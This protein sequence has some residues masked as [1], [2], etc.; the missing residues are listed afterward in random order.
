M[1]GSNAS[2]LVKSDKILIDKI[3]KEIEHLP[4]LPHVVTKVVEMTQST[5]TNIEGISATL[6]QS[7]AAKVLKMANSAY[8]GGGRSRNV[9]SIRHA[10]V[11]IGFDALKEIV[12]TASFF[13]TFHDARDVQSLQPLWE[14]SQ[15]AAQIAKRM[16]WIYGYSNH[17]EAYFSGLV[18]D[19]GK[20]V[21]NQYFPEQYRMIQDLIQKG[22]EEADAEKATIGLNHAEIGGKVCNFWGFPGSVADAISHHHDDQW[23]VNPKLGMILSCADRFVLGLYDF[24]KVLDTCSTAEM[25]PP[26]SWDESDLESVERILQEELLKAQA[27]FAVSSPPGA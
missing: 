1:A 16:A 3:L 2:T 26:K 7:L 8:Y 27:L 22:S 6:D 9:N 13:H 10:I 18:H 25:F 17:D 23:K 12:L 24:K 14:H 21:L 19:V 20:L 5:D 4:T 15:S 11:I